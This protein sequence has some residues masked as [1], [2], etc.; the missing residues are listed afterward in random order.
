MTHAWSLHMPM[1]WRPWAFLLV[2]IVVAVLAEHTSSSSKQ[3]K[4]WEVTSTG[5]VSGDFLPDAYT[6]NSPDGG[7]SPP[8]DWSKH[9]PSGVQQY[10]I[11]RTNIP[12]PDSDMS[13]DDWDV[14]HEYK[15]RFD[16]VVYDVSKKTTSVKADGSTKIGTLGGTFPGVEYIYRS[17]CS[18]GQGMKQVTF[19]VHALNGDLAEKVEKKKTCD[20]DGDECDVG[21]Y[22]HYYAQKHD[23]IIDTATIDVWYCGG[24]SDEE[25]KAYCDAADA[26][27]DLRKACSKAGKYDA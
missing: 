26:D 11:T 24:C 10:L 12:H 27:G 14:T 8:L 21:W 5:F 6:C 4:K 20:D 1:P 13:G 22:M 15:T 19:S 23:M 7:V 3:S 25:V 2:A 16:W 9:T 17:S 18:K